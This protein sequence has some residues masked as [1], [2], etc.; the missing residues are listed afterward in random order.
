VTHNKIH[1]MGNC[2]VP[3]GVAGGHHW[4][5]REGKEPVELSSFSGFGDRN[6]EC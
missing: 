4:W 3:I 6:L 1:E 2:K 5:S